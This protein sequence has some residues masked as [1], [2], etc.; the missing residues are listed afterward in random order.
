MYRAKTKRQSDK[1]VFVHFSHVSSLSV[2]WIWLSLLTDSERGELC[3]QNEVF[4]LWCLVYH[5]S[6]SVFT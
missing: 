1:C 4:I 6:D 2:D 5:S 3:N